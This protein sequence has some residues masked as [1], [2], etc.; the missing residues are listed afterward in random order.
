MNAL[1][2]AVKYI[3]HTKGCDQTRMG[4]SIFASECKSSS[5]WF[6]VDGDTFE[7][8]P[9]TPNITQVT[10]HR[11]NKYLAR[12]RHRAFIAFVLNGKTTFSAFDMRLII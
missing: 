12:R 9:A 5:T 2:M 10:I 7:L 6:D 1:T 4:N 11:V 3:A 8:S